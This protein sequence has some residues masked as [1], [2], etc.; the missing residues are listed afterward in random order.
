MLRT[1]AVTAGRS[2]DNHIAVRLALANKLINEC[3]LGTFWPTEA[4]PDAEPT[5]QVHAVMFEEALSNLASKILAATMI[6]MQGEGDE[7]CVS[8]TTPSIL[9]HPTGVITIYVNRNIPET[10]G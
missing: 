3:P 6:R 7:F 4:R 2:H 5:V 8:T 9:V 1:G 10:L